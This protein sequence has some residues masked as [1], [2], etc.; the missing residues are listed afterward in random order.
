MTCSLLVGKV[1]YQPNCALALV[2]PLQVV[3]PDQQTALDEVVRT[4]LTPL[5]RAIPCS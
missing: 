4:P 1:R 3:D 2:P 5:V